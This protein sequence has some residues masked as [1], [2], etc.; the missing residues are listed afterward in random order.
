MPELPEVEQVAFQ[1]DK[2]IRG[3][4]FTNISALRKKNAVPSASTVNRKLA[5]KRVKKVWRRAK[6]VIIEFENNNYLTVHLRMTGQL[7]V[8]STEDEV[9][10]YVRALLKFE[11][12][13]V[14]FRDIRAFGRVEYLDQ[15]GFEWVVA[16]FGPEPLEKS[17]TEQ[18]FLEILEK[19]KTRKI[20]QLLLDQ[21]IIAGIGNIYA[22]EA[23]YIVKIH[24]EDSAKNIPILKQKKL[25]TT[26]RAILKKA[27]EV[28]GCSDNTYRDIYNQKGI[29]NKY[30]KVYRKE[31]EKCNVCKKDTI[32]RIVV[33]QRGTFI[34]PTCQVK[35]ND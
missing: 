13:F 18:V 19:K 11:D 34:C 26:L 30:L 16:R 22:N 21:A 6:L 35:N 2:E 29:F 15:K 33:G 14:W 28:G 24:P 3:K 4:S 7:L 8:K 20:K 12:I 23:L 17:F 9:D 25:Y 27:V 31:G 10:A 5:G 32:A 1:L